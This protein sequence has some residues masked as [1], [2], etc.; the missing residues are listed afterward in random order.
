MRIVLDTNIIIS[1]LLSETGPPGLLLKLWLEGKF[2]LLISK[3]QLNELSRVFEYKKIRERIPSDQASDFLGHIDT[4]TV[5]IDPLLNIGLSP[6]PDDNAILAAAIESRADF[7]VSGDKTD[8]LSLKTA[9]GIP[10]LTARQAIKR[11][12]KK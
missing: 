9:E 8:L 12:G 2:E 3:A 11:L 4:L 10:I 7:I 5:V 6:D 1:G